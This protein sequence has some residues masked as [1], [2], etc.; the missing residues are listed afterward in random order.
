MVC[1]PQIGLGEMRILW[2]HL[3]C[4]TK[5][6]HPTEKSRHT[7]EQVAFGLHQIEHGTPMA[8]VCR[9]MGISK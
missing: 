3:S 2:D 1:S 7:P 4:W 8:K 6:D 9:K 5:E